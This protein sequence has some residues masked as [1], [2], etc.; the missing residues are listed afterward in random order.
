MN[1]KPTTLITGAAKRIGAAIARHLAGQGHDLVLHYNHSQEEADALAAEL[2]GMGATVTLLQADLE[3]L[4]A[5][6]VFWHHAPPCS[7]IIHNASRYA[8]DKIDSFTVTD[9]RSHLAVNLE[10]PIILTQGF[11][12]QM[13]ANTPGNVIL[14]GDDA[15]GWSNSPEFFTYAISKHSWSSIIDLLA[16]ACAPQVRMNMIALA[17]TLPGETDDTALFK[18]LAKKAP[19]GRTGAVPEVLAAI[20]F[21][22]AS[23]GL[24]GQRIGLGN[25]MGLTTS[26]ALKQ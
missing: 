1:H 2:R 16:S 20:D 7:T 5:R 8:R 15:L 6:E 19:L 13:P 22:L 10:A 26:R 4:P 11:L 9:L 23:P 24:T 17:P 18:R 21:V 25:G 12:A 3:H 14:L